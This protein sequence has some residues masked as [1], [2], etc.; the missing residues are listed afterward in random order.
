MHF[1]IST[2][3]GSSRDARG[4]APVGP[5]LYRIDLGKAVFGHAGY[6]RLDVAVPYLNEKTVAVG[7]EA[8]IDRQ[9]AGGGPHRL[10]ALVTIGKQQLS[11]LSDLGDPNSRSTCLACRRAQGTA[12]GSAPGNSELRRGKRTSLW[13]HPDGNPVSCRARPGVAGFRRRYA[14]P[15][16]VRSHPARRS[17]LQS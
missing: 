1:L 16:F 5:G 2:A 15:R 10:P 8:D 3:S 12:E 7:R 17:P 13:G 9:V 11:N 4:L 14:R 6:R